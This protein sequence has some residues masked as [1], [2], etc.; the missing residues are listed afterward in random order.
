MGCLAHHKAPW[1]QPTIV[2]A[3]RPVML[4][5]FVSGRTHIAGQGGWTGWC[6]REIPQF[7]PK[8]PMQSW[9]CIYSRSKPGVESLT[10]PSSLSKKNYTWHKRF[11]GAA[12]FFVVAQ[13]EAVYRSNVSSPH[14][15]MI[16]WILLLL[17]ACAGRRK[18]KGR[19]SR[20]SDN[21][22]GPQ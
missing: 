10:Q 6:G 3:V 13:F 1:A 20:H 2:C 4:W 16:F 14:S 22:N 19:A 12:F 15:S 18:R 7:M 5:R 8:K 11:R 17:S 21:T 9:Y